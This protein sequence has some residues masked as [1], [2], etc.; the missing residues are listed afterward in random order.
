M[1][2]SPAYH[3]KRGLYPA[4]GLWIRK[5]GD[6]WLLELVGPH[7]KRALLGEYEMPHVAA[8]A[9]ATFKT[10]NADWDQM[11]LVAPALV[12]DFERRGFDNLKNWTR[13]D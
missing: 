2:S 7:G 8:T 3:L 9:A 11:P 5:S 6:G 10:G 12:D 1:P 4:D 13:V